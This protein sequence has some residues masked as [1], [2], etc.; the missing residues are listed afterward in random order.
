MLDEI[1]A[2][3]RVNHDPA[4]PDLPDGSGGLKPILAGFRVDIPDLHFTLG[5]LIAKG[6]RVVTRCTMRGTHLG[7]FADL[8]STARK[9]ISGDMQ[10][11]RV[12]NGKISEHWRR[13][14]DLGLMQQLGALCTPQA[15]ATK[16]STRPVRQAISAGIGARL[17]RRLA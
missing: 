15:A 11:E 2:P 12:I 13:L 5:G 8:P 14:D 4:V 16:H 17:F 7:K 3:N 10:I 1:V 9:V 6:D